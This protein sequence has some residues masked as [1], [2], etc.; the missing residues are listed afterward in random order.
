[1]AEYIVTGLEPVK[2]K[3]GWFEL[4][5]KDKPPLFVNEEVILTYDLAVGFIFSD[6]KL[7]KIKIDSDLAWVK[8]RAMQILNRRI[9]SE[10]DLRIKLSAERRSAAVVSEVLTQLKEYGFVDDLKYAGAYIRSQLSRGAKSKLYLKKKLWEK[11]INAEIALTAMNQELEEYD[12]TGAVIELARKKYKTLQK[13]PPDKAKNRLIS[14]LKGRGFGWDTIRAT[15]ENVIN[16]KED[17]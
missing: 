10:R 9:I 5:I 12:E 15:L 14:Y 17:N 7:K 16:N 2:R 1:M 4:F 11:G 13:L 6:A 3:K 8:Y